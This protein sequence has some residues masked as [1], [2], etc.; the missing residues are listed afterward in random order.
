VLEVEQRAELHIYILL[1]SSRLIHSKWV[2][3]D[4]LRPDSFLGLICLSVNDGVGRY[5]TR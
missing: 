2:C 4:A 5:G 3:F 1:Q